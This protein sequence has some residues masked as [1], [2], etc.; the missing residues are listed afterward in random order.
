MSGQSKRYQQAALAEIESARDQGVDYFHEHPDILLIAT[1]RH[2]AT[3]FPG[4][5]HQIAFLQGYSQARSQ[6]EEFMMESER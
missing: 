6:H 1:A 2:A 3:L 5:Q 4:K